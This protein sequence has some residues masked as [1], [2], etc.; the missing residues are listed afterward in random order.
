MQ[1]AI[2]Y[3]VQAGT[4]WSMND[5]MKN[6]VKIPVSDHMYTTKE[7]EEVK[8]KFVLIAEFTNK[9]GGK[10]NGVFELKRINIQ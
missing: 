2:A 8:I 7:Y 5:A 4:F 1:V 6:R 3:S 10:E 9:T